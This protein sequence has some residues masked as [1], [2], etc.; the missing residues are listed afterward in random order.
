MPAVN[1]AAD[2]ASVEQQGL[3][4]HPYLT[5]PI[6]YI[7]GIDANMSDAELAKGPFKKLLPIR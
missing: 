1:W 4:P 5:R 2:K 7:S 3:P 6:L